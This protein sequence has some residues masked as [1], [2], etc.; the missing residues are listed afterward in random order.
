MARGPKRAP[1]DVEGEVLTRMELEAVQYA[2]RRL[3]RIEGQAVA[4]RAAVG[5]NRAVVALSGRSRASV[6]TAISRG[7]AKLRGAAA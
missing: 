3:T 7:R 1:A 4:A 5:S 6:A 2:L